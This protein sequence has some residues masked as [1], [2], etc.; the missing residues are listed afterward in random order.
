MTW[1]VVSIE[2]SEPLR[3]LPV[4][5]EHAGLH[6]VFF[7]NGVPLGHCQLAGAQL[8]ASPQH[9]A[10]HAAKAIALA[11]GDYLLEEGFR[12]ALPGL[13]EMPPE[14]PSMALRS[15]IELPNPVQELA[16]HLPVRSDSHLTVSIAVCTR[17]RPHELARCLASLSELSEHALE[18][19]V[20]DNAPQS[21]R[22]RE[23]VESFPGVRYVLEP[24]R[25]LSAARN[26]AM[27]L[28]SGGIIAF[29]DDDTVVHPNWLAQIRQCFVD[30]KVMV[31]TGLVLPAE[32]ETPAQQIFEHNLHFFHQGYRRRRFDAAYFAAM[33]NKGVPVWEIGAGANMAIRRRAYELG[34]RFD[35]RLGPGVFGGCGEDSEF[36][37]GIL[38]AGSSCVYDPTACV[39]H[40]HRREL[41][42]LRHLVN[43]YM[44]GHV[45]ALLLQ[46]VKYGD[47]GNLRRLLVRLPAEY[48]VLL[49]RLIVSGFAIDYR[50]LLRGVL[51][52]LAGLRFAFRKPLRA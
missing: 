15:L 19:L 7:L 11:A 14:S 40:Y 38:A 26:T 12:S 35:T 52:Y 21:T 17:E 45:A 44:Q 9:M 13:P 33:R 30:P 29:V 51:G 24:R 18:V 36:W 25:G 47:I 5:S 32:L 46:F 49:L 16:Q 20:I 41:A 22:T 1:K 42:D 10:N 50:I 4:Y 48:A 27:A 6:V 8:P 23:I 3:E 43:Q 31:V 34:H 28:A 37:Y 39:F 2:L